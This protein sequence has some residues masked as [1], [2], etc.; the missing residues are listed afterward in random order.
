MNYT[1]H[2]ILVIGI[3]FLSSLDVLAQ[4]SDIMPDRSAESRTG[5]ELRYYPTRNLKLSIEQQLRFDDNISVFDKTYTEINARYRFWNQLDLGIGYRYIFLNDN[6]GQEQGIEKYY[7]IHYYISH[8][9]EFNRFEMKNR[10]KFQNRKEI[11]DNS[12][13]CLEEIRNCWRVK[14]SLNYNIKRCKFDPFLSAEIFLPTNQWE[15]KLHNRY[16][17]SIGADIKLSKKQKISVEYMF[18][19]EIKSWNPEIFHIIQI[20]YIFSIKRKS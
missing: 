8:Q 6:H 2:K 7:R 1:L 19:H 16:R 14:S 9:F 15:N 13:D 18:D 10:I 20:N 11:L 5:A 12:I 3:L 17:L 4:N